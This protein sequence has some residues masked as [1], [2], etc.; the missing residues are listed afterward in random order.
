MKRRVKARSILEPFDVSQDVPPVP[1]RVFV[2]KHRERTP[3][4]VVVEY[5]KMMIH[6]RPKKRRKV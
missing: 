1:V 2:V 4:A 5:G 6:E 3:K